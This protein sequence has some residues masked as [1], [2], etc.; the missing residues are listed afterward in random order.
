MDH[1]TGHHRS[2]PLHSAVDTAYASKIWTPRATRNT[3][4]A[5]PSKR[6][7][8]LPDPGAGPNLTQASLNQPLACAAESTA[9][10]RSQCAA[11]ASLAL[12]AACSVGASLCAVTLGVRGCVTRV[13]RRG[14]TR[15]TALLAHTTYQCYTLPMLQS[16]QQSA[17]P[18]GDR[19]STCEPHETAAFASWAPSPHFHVDHTMERRRERRCASVAT[20][21]ASELP[22]ST[23]PLARRRTTQAP[24]SP[25]S[26]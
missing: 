11:A 16:I 25:Q 26:L 22:Q 20:T 12:R 7:L 18:L 5:R 4:R 23:W 19:V 24:L 15:H 2:P 14:R 1:H 8:F 21:L 17:V 9:R 13:R 10:L 3:R 6:K